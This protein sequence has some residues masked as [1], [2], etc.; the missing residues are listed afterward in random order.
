[1]APLYVSP[2][3]LSVSGPAK[4]YKNIETL[5]TIALPVSPAPETECELNHALLSLRNK[6]N[7]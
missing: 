7:T 5:S 3:A 2:P 1:M 6:Y 4:P